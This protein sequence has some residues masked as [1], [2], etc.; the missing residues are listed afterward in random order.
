MA[1]GAAGAGGL[2]SSNRA[3]VTLRVE[4]GERPRA[5]FAAAAFAG[6]RRVGLGHGAQGVE[7]IPAVQADVLVD[8]H[9]RTRILSP[10]PGSV[11]GMQRAQKSPALAGVIWECARPGPSRPGQARTRARARDYQEPRRAQRRCAPT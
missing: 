3:T 5:M 8:R 6:E 11:N 1:A 4:D 10:Y 2:R 7:S 9:G